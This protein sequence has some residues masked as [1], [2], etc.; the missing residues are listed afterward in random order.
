MI[1][2]GPIPSRRLGQ[3]LGINHI[4]PKICSYDCIY[5]QVGPT[6]RSAIERQQFFEVDKVVEAVTQ[7]VEEKRAANKQIDYL[8]FVPDGEPTLDIR[9]GEMIDALKP[10]GIKIGVITN[11]SLLWREDVQEELCKA[12]LV[13]IKVDS[14]EESSWSKVN[15]PEGGLSLK[16][17]LEGQLA[18][19]KKFNGTLI[20]ETML[21]KG[22][23]DKEPSLE[24]TAQ[25][26]KKLNPDTAY[27]AVP[28]RP[29]SESWAGTP[30]E[31]RI[32]RAYQ[33]FLKQLDKVE[34]LLGFSPDS[35]GVT[36]DV[37]QSILDITAVHPMRESELLKVLEEGGFSRAKLDE[38]LKEEKLV[39]IEHEG[40]PFYLRKMKMV[41][42]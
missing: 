19:A 36:G 22:A 9:L 28:T 27:I 7:K 33:I 32:N 40:Q 30:D 21:V 23:N 42:A 39:R 3:S 17:M 26:L 4:P 34:C 15:R 18:F 5:C 14:V 38:L 8:T 31:E 16:K 37:I 12:D 1:A 24:A 10:L 11:G 2:F 25:Y 41:S 20:T 29:P 6:S 35:F 13:S